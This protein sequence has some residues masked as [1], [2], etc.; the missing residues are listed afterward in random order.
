MLIV[1]DVI[2][3]LDTDYYNPEPIDLEAFQMLLV[4]DFGGDVT[5][6]MRAVD[7]AV[8]LSCAVEGI[9][10]Q[11][12]TVLRQALKE[13]VKPKTKKKVDIPKD[14]KKVSKEKESNKPTEGPKVE[15]DQILKIREKLNKDQKQF[16]EVE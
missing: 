13:K 10:P 15:S 16:Q 2:T 12:E 3:L 14:K 8:V 1:N 5:R 9:M 6:A 11:T 7:G 4:D